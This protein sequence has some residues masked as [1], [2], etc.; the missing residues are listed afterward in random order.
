MH[1]MRGKR[2]D[3]AGRPAGVVV[4]LA[5]SAC[6]LAGHACTPRCS[7]SGGFRSRPSSHMYSQSCMQS[8][9]TPQSLERE[10]RSLDLSAS[11]QYF[12]LTI[13]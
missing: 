4:Y 10:R 1:E 13:N 7:S 3:A 2:K 12:F 9:T 6:L 5:T 8:Q 11:Q